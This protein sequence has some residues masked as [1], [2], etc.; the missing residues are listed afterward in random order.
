[1]VWRPRTSDAFGSPVTL[2]AFQGAAPNAACD[3]LY[4][5][6]PGTAGGLD[7]FVATR[8]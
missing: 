3:S 5:S 1:V 4:Y 2:G 8:Q 6:A 7:L